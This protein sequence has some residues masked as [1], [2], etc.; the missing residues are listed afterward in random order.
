MAA[1]A[2]FV[3]LASRIIPAIFEPGSAARGAS[4]LQ[5]AFLLCIALILFTWRRAADLKAVAEAVK[6]AEQQTYLLAYSDEVTKLHNRRFLSEQ[7]ARCSA[8][9]HV[10]SILLLIDIDNFKNVNDLYGHPAGDALLGAIADR[11]VTHSPR[12]ACCARLGGD[13]FAILIQ[14][15]DAETTRATALAERLLDAIQQP[16]LLGSTIA[17]VTASL[18]LSVFDPAEEPASLMRRS[19]I[20]MY[21]AK[22]QGRNRYSWFDEEMERLLNARNSLEVE[23]RAGLAADQFVP[24]FQVLLDLE[25]GEPHGF[26]VLARWEHPTKGLIEP[27][28]FIPAAEANGMISE[29]SHRVMRKAFVIARAWPQHL[30]MSV[31]I[32]PVQFKDPALAFKILKLLTE[33]GFN[34]KRLE[35]EITESTLLENRSLTSSTVESLKNA[36]IR[37][38]LDDFGTGYASLSQLRELPF[39]RIKIDR[40]FVAALFDD[41]ESNAIVHAVAT[42]GKTLNLP[43]TAEG[44]ETELAHQRVKSLGCTD[45]QGWLFGKAMSAQDTAKLFHL[46]C[47]SSEMDR[48]ASSKPSIAAVRK[49]AAR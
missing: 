47:N 34:P 21:D 46:E 40:S 45:A 19:D 11:I 33:T 8:G 41:E 5:P 27:D 38:S 49:Y 1:I 39:D 6:R 44:V 42:L 35:I 20:A 2:I 32:S 18:G 16:I 37:I 24:F 25:S 9:E 26:E 17:S 14:G 23:M 29:L 3:A 15:Q 31:N 13:E 7:I 10:P 30:T 12:G 48:A 43:I 4:K 36:G 28:R 22:A